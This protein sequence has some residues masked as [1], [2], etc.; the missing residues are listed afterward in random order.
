MRKRAATGAA[1]C[2]SWL[3]LALTACAAPTIREGAPLVVT[4]RVIAPHD[5]HETCVK[6]VPGDRLDYQFKAKS[7]VAFNIHYHEG[8]VIV[9]PISRD[10]TTSDAGIFVPR[11]AQEYC[12]MWEAGPD[13]TFLDYRVTLNR[14]PREVRR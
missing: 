5:S 11:Y 7:P 12:L 4:D 14:G 6:L 10:G 8:K 9:M 1:G 13:G 2:A 3:A